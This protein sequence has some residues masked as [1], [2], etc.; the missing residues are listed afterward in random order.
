VETFEDEVEEAAGAVEEG[1][2]DGT[3]P[4][5]TCTS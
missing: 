2:N 4:L 3:A 1:V 5:D